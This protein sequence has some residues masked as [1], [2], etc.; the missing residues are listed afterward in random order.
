M[1][2]PDTILLIEDNEDDAY[3]M[4]QA[5]RD[6]EIVNPLRH[7]EDGQAAIDY[8]AGHGEFADR[9]KHPIPMVVF[10]DLKLPY[11]NGHEVLQWIRSQPAF[12]KLV[13]I[14][15]TSSDEPVDLKRSYQ[16]GANSYVVKPP[17]PEQLLDLAEAFKL[18]WLRHNRVG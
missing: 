5:L 6:A 2:R 7:V 16:L 13:V 9:V 18:W 10:L 17:T 12:E 11:K 14:V 1:N 4:K 15:L 8:L 3:F